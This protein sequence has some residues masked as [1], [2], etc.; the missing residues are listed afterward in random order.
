MLIPVSTRTLSRVLVVLFLTL[1]TIWMAVA[2]GGPATHAEADLPSPISLNPGTPGAL[3]WQIETVDD[4]TGTVYFGNALR[5]DAS[6]RPCLAYY[7]PDE[8]YDP[9]EGHLTY[10]CR[11]VTWQIAPVDATADVGTYNALA[12]GADDVPHVSYYDASAGH[13]KYATFDGTRWLSTTV[14]AASDAGKFTSIALDASDNPWISYYRGGTCGTDSFCNLRYAVYDGAWSAQQLHFSTGDVGRHSSLAFDAHGHPHLSYYDA[15]NGSL[16]YLHHDG[17]AWNTWQVVDSAGNV[18][19]DTSLALD[20]AGQPHIAYWDVTG[21]NLR[22]ATH[23]GTRWITHT[24]DSGDVGRS[25][26]LALDAAGHPHVTYYDLGQ[27]TLKYAFHDGATWQIRTVDTTGPVSGFEGTSLVLDPSGTPHVSYYTTSGLKYARVAPHRVYVPLISRNYPPPPAR[28]A[29]II[30]VADY[31]YDETSPDWCFLSDLPYPDDD[32]VKMQQLL[33]DQGGFEPDNVLTLVDGQATKAAI[34]DAITGWLAS[35]V[36]PHDLVVIFYHGHGGQL[37]DAFPYDDE[38]DGVDEWLVPTDWDC[39]TDTAI[40]DDELDTWLDTLASQHV[41]LFVDS[42]FS[43]GLFR[44]SAANE[45]P[46]H[47]RCLPPLPGVI[48]KPVVEP[49]LPLDV[50]QDG[51]LILTASREDQESYECDSLQSGVFSYYL[52]QAL[53]SGAADLHDHNGWVSGEE[54]FEYLKPR[55]EAEMCYQPWFQHP[56]ISDGIAGEQDLTQP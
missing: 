39:T 12:L 20:A 30:G 9:G 32:A 43:G 56:Q 40:A 1:V 44:A 29:L 34:K 4:S 47:S 41:V 33:L 53:Q 19:A 17:S 16:R 24:V 37:G 42:C 13:L 8:G 7:H 38:V 3:N 45:T 52:R 46:C 48:V 27:D 10:G 22:Y 25:A 26:S 14:D 6:G 11:D 55:V 50:G 49:H 31:L 36:H 23:D 15:T 54:A 5:L 51:R 28:Y 21:D 18:G 2:G 35:R